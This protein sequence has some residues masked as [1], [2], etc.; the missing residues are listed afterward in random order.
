MIYTCIMTLHKKQQAV[1]NFAIAMT[2]Q[3]PD[4]RRLQMAKWKDCHF[5]MYSYHGRIS[6]QLWPT[7][8]WT[9]WTSSPVYDQSSQ[10][11]IEVAWGKYTRWKI[12]IP[13]LAGFKSLED[14][15]SKAHWGH[16]MNWGI[17]YFWTKPKKCQTFWTISSNIIKYY[18]IS[19]N[20]I[21]HPHDCWLV[22]PSRQ[23][24]TSHFFFMFG[25]CSIIISHSQPWC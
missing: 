25:S 15:R 17:P 24:A 2:L 10:I 20:I 21:G 6:L 19:S 16:Q 13:I 23:W 3:E 8:P 18:H 14:Q 12:T 1:W 9:S 7:E 4:V 11:E 22:S 5:P